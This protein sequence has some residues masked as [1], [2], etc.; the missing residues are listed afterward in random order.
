MGKEEKVKDNRFAPK[1]SLAPTEAAVPAPYSS[2]YTEDE[3]MVIKVAHAKL[4]DRNLK[5]EPVTLEEF[6]TIVIPWQRINRTE[7]F[8]LNPDKVKAVRE[9]KAPRAPRTPRE[10]VAKAPKEVKLTKKYISERL[11]DIIFQMAAGEMVSEEDTEFFNLH[12]NRT[13]A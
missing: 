3:I 7:V 1:T 2:G 6:K 11:S 10:K 12:T 5:V 13:L 9:P 8:T 4:S